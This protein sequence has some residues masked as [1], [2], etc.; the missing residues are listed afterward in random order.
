M[1]RALTVMF[2]GRL[3]L[4]LLATIFIV[5]LS[6]IPAAWAC[7]T[8]SQCKNGRVCVN[9]SCIAPPATTL[10]APPKPTV[11]V[12]PAAPVP[13]PTDRVVLKG[14]AEF[15]GDITEISPETLLI[16]VRGGAPQR[17]TWDQVSLAERRDGSKVVRPA[18]PPP[19]PAP[20]TVVA[21][22][23][24]P[25]PPAAP[26]SAA[27]APVVGAAPSQVCKGGR[28]LFQGTCSD[29][30]DL[31]A[32][33]ERAGVPVARP[34]DREPAAGTPAAQPL[35]A[36]EVVRTAAPPEASRVEVSP[37]A[38][39]LGLSVTQTLDSDS[40]RRKWLTR[41]GAIFNGALNANL[42]GFYLSKGGIS[43]SG[44]GGGL[45]LRLGLLFLSAPDPD[46]GSGFF[47]FR[48]GSGIDASAMAVT[49]SGP[50]SSTQASGA[51]SI[52]FYA[53]FQFGGGSFNS[54]GEWSG[55]TV[56]IS[57][58]PSYYIPIDSNGPQ[59]GSF[60]TAGV[61]LELSPATLNSLAPEAHFRLS[62][63]V[64]PP[65]ND[66][67]LLVNLGFGAVWY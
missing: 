54:A 11:V 36:R 67:P 37:V 53:G 41:G 20:A 50:F 44:G 29:P 59:D 28:V 14:G 7:T 26:P 17:F 22:V 39:G 65:I 16:V 48:L 49:A 19:A 6:N 23:P 56:G 57:W 61:T 31:P 45:G 66:L 40:K 34:G 64:L 35:A 3:L 52:P 63:F 33:A 2:R 32:T 62:I 18:P 1:P 47:G 43:V 12:P 8:D 51:I 46:K 13:V 58:T 5:L 10:P 15:S 21:P 42:T 27:P 4:Y 38:Q 30:A 55:F 60:N 9:T 25:A 24:A